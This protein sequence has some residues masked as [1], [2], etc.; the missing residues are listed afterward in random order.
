MSAHVDARDRKPFSDRYVFAKVMQDNSDLCKE[1][2]ECVLGIE[3]SRV[4]V[5]EVESGVAMITRR[6]VRY[7][8]F[9]D[10]DEA[11][12]EVEMQTY[13][14][15]ALPLRMRYYRSLLDRRMLGR[16]EDFDKLKPV[17]II[18]ICKQDYFG[19]GLPVYTFVN[20]CKEDPRAVFDDKTT[21]VILCASGDLSQASS[22]V[23]GLLQY[24][25]TGDPGGDEFSERLQKA[26]NKAYDD[27]DWVNQMMP[28]E[29]DLRD[30][31]RSGAEEGR[32]EGRA[33][34]ESASDAQWKELVAAMK[35]AGLSDEELVERLS[36][37]DRP[38]LCA[39]YGVS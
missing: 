19:L 30:A 9:L 36:N 16:G 10:S 5:I 17:Y 23:A 20:T 28:L 14:Q 4:E 15:R 24:V 8:V 1:L 38:S 25:L 39:E 2:I 37:S 13:D 35:R 22:S 18:F 27:E 21:N 34:G 3:V 29:W 31:K 7:D 33:E 32:A 12:F 6:S 11:A 26:V